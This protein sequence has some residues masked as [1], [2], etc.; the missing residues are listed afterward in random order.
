MPEKQTY[1]ELERRIELLEES[2]REKDAILDLLPD[3]LVIQD[4][5]HRI[6]W[7]NQ[8]ACVS[9]RL[10]RSEI[11][12]RKCHELWADQ[13]IPCRDCPMP[14][15]VKQG[16]NREIKKNTP[17]GR[18]WRI[19]CC[20]IQSR[21]YGKNTKI[22]EVTEDITDSVKT[23]TEQ[24][25][26]LD[27]MQEM[28]AY[29]DTDLRVKWANKAAAESVGKA[30]E[31]L[32]G[33]HCYEIWQM[34]DAP[35]DGCPVLKA[36]K[37]RK[38]QES[39]AETPDGRV[40]K[41]RGYPVLDEKKQLIGAVE[42]GLDITEA[43]KAEVSL[44][45]S[46]SLLNHSQKIADVGSFVWNLQNDSLYWSKNMYAIHGLD[47]ETFSGNLTDVSGQL[48]HPDDRDRVGVEIQKMIEEKSIRSM[49]FRI[50]RPDGQERIMQSNGEFELNELGKPVKCFGIHQDITE[51]KRIED[52][53]RESEKKFRLLFENS[54]D[55][56]VLYEIDR[57]VDCNHACLNML[58][59]T[60][61]AQLLSMHPADISPQYQKDGKPS[62]QKAESMIALAFEKGSHRFD[63]L[64]QKSDGSELILDVLLNVIKIRGEDII[65]GVWRD[66]TKQKLSENALRE[67]EKKYR[68]LVD[69]IPY[70][71]EEIDLNGRRIF[72]N[73]AYHNMLGYKPGELVDSYV[74]DHDPTEESAKKVKEYFDY[75]K[76]KNLNQN[77]TFQKT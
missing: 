7:A 76:M 42:Y 72:F 33:K 49:Q 64:C 63:W 47:K 59:I 14:E 36:I 9:L 11:L 45:E 66:I 25:L 21:H 46:E 69:T 75:I 58:G 57:F 19:R 22:L 2:L 32:V 52:A 24:K 55:A 4:L 70:G 51:R 34:R 50:I 71:V 28:L 67:N 6:L 44:I 54:A 27:T 39:V 29:H 73:D 31:D 8:A 35:C 13:G 60:K 3:H 40:F 23:R 37:T 16:G 5:E 17:D 12:N 26:I 30:P 1:E 38:A 56:H 62:R 10:D 68:D 61:K 15:A 53:L 20:P 43:K 18:S 65:H 48:I 74:W 77:H 41:I